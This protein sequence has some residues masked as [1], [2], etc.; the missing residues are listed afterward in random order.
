MTSSD[1]LMRALQYAA[2][3]GVSVISM[4]WGSEVD[5][6]F[7]ETAMN[8]A[9]ENGM[10]AAAVLLMDHGADVNARHGGVTPLHKA[11]YNGLTEMT[12]LLLERGADVNAVD[13]YG[14]T[15]LHLAVSEQSWKQEI[16]TKNG[17]TVREVMGTVKLLL[18]RGADVHAANN[19]GETALHYAAED[20]F[21]ETVRLLIDRG[22]DVHKKD[23]EGNTA[24]LFAAIKGHEKVAAVLL[25]KGAEVDVCAGQGCMSRSM[26]MYLED[27]DYMGMFSENSFGFTTVCLPK[28][29]P[30]AGAA[31]RGHKAVMELLLDAGADIDA[32]GELGETP[33]IIAASRGHCPV[34]T[35]LLEKGAKVNH[36]DQN[37]NTALIAAAHNSH[38][39][40]IKALLKHKADP[41]LK[42]LNG[43]T[44]LSV[45]KSDEVAQLLIQAGATKSA[46]SARKAPQAQ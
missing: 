14:N 26:G 39:Y 4:S 40:V 17:E 31:V 13:Q 25:E 16:T 33:L 36:Q 10:L 5:S 28:Y 44:A 37:G 15:P 34:T 19:K 11:A 45:A 23:R 20:G 42:N 46:A 8:Y 3:S 35:M 27:T 18:A 1:T 30:L 9:A 29:T 12:A 41:N 2:E 6:A 7:I 43:R 38:V 22:A 21:T 24:L 32:Q